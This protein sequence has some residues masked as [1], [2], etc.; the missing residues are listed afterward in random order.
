MERLLHAVMGVSL[1]LLAGG[2]WTENFAVGQMQRNGWFHRQG[3][4]RFF[5]ST[6]RVI[7]AH[8][9]SGGDPRWVRL[10]KIASAGTIVGF[11]GLLTMLIAVCIL[12]SH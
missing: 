12:V 3:W 9:A 10:Q 1:V 2:A 5:I 8:Q 7:A 11:A 4:K 6:K